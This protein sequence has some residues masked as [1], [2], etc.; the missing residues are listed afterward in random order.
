LSRTECYCVNCARTLFLFLDRLLLQALQFC[1]TT[2]PYHK[3]S[4]EDEPFPSRSR[5]VERRRM[6]YPPSVSPEVYPWPGHLLLCD[7]TAVPLR[8]I[9]SQA[10]LATSLTPSPAPPVENT[11][12]KKQKTAADELADAPPLPPPSATQSTNPAL[13]L[14]PCLEDYNFSDG[15]LI[16][17]TNALPKKE[18]YRSRA[19]A[20]PLR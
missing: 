15:T 9:P 2:R 14:P 18:F 3:S 7:S 13:T 5:I 17:P 1:V 16:T 8:S 10:K 12:T 20:N 4:L 19:H 6:R 11:M